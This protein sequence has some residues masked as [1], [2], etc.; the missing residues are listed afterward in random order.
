LA[1]NL[2]KV[3][4][5][6]LQGDKMAYQE[7]YWQDFYEKAWAIRAKFMS[8]CLDEGMNS[9][10]AVNMLSKMERMNVLGM[11]NNS[12]EMI[13]Y[14]KE[15]FENNVL[16]FA[17]VP[18]IRIS[19]RLDKEIIVPFH[20]SFAV[21]D[22]LIDIFDKT[23]PYDSITELGCGYGRNLFEIFYKGGATNVPYYGGEFTES[24]V[25]IAT[26]LAAATP[27]MN[28]KFFHFNHLEPNLDG[29]DFGERAFIFT[30]HSIEQ[31]K[32]IPQSWFNVVA[33]AA[34]YVRCTHIEPFSFQDGRDDVIS[35]TQREFFLRQGWNLNLTETILEAVKQKVIVLDDIVMNIG[36]STDPYN[37]S[38]LAFW[39]SQKA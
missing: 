27:K 19:S 3:L 24:G 31:V 17:Q 37:P 32:E 18:I 5:K 13:W 23:G 35:N 16:N 36:L 33:N 21:A 1:H 20:S 22:M 11:D 8:D 2:L 26:K 39:H 6:N 7:K 10:Q 15:T 30:C 9:Y 4:F 25:E 38:S 34:P 29:F 28:A 12:G 14:K